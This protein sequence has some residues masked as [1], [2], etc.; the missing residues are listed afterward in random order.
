MPKSGSFL[1]VDTPHVI[2][3]AV[4]QSEDGDDLIVRC[5]EVAGQP[6]SAT[7]DLVFA[8]RKWKGSFSPFEIKSL[9]IVKKSGEVKEVNLLEE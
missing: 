9:R 6:T 4:K 3:S 8:G 1:A 7:L 5:V 2:A